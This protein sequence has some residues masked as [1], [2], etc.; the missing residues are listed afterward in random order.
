MESWVVPV[1]G[2]VSGLGG[3]LLSDVLKTAFNL[4][5]TDLVVNRRKLKI[6]T[7]RFE[8]IMVSALRRHENL[9]RY[10][11]FAEQDNWLAEPRDDVDLE[12]IAR[13]HYYYLVWCYDLGVLLSLLHYSLF[14][15]AALIRRY[16]GRQHREFLNRLQL[17]RDVV[18][19]PQVIRGQSAPT[20]ENYWI[21]SRFLNSIYDFM[22]KEKAPLE[23]EPITFSQFI[24]KYSDPEEK[25]FRL[26]MGLVGGFVSLPEGSTF[27][28]ERFDRLI[29]LWSMI[30]FALDA[31]KGHRE[32]GS[33]HK[34]IAKEARRA[35]LLHDDGAWA[36]GI[37]RALAWAEKQQA[38]YEF[39]GRFRVLLNQVS[40]LRGAGPEPDA[41]AASGPPPGS[42]SAPA[43]HAPS[44]LAP[45][46]APPSDNPPETAL[47][48]GQSA[49][50]PGQQGRAGRQ[51]GRKKNRPRSGR[52]GL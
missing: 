52:A 17:V 18:T 3:A 7:S 32:R 20:E 23:P 51:G 31:L 41:A 8:S 16:G 15:R 44:G 42:A 48:L 39:N 11:Q 6:Y 38:D 2:A 37:E 13:V 29:C 28:Q 21:Y 1:I 5:L 27:Q 40:T 35:G 33:Y 19:I 34:R 12:Q 26:W 47:E 24:R 46:G 9:F 49:P 36:E 22:I 4:E 25:E 10:R 30:T 45:D 14:E 43:R 50:G